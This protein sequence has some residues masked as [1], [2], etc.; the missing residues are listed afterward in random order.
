MTM[1]VYVHTFL[2]LSK[3]AEDLINT[4][5]KKVDRCIDGLNVAY[6]EHVVA[7]KRPDTFDDAVE[8]AFSAK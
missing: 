7:L 4:E 5:E 1:A 3:Y 6:M 8:S 2:R